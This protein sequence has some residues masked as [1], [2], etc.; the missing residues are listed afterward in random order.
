MFP[1]KLEQGR[2]PNWFLP[3]PNEYASRR[4]CIAPQMRIHEIKRSGSL[5]AAV[6]AVFQSGFAPDSRQCNAAESANLSDQL[7]VRY[8]S[9][10]YLCHER[11]EGNNLDRS[12]LTKKGR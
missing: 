1:E 5:M 9:W 7:A 3:R 8:D 12:R 2:S 4:A 11:C 10:Y 6:A